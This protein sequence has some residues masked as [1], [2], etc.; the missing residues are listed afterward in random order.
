M[1]TR[2]QS[3]EEVKVKTV[4]LLNMVTSTEPQHCFERWKAPRM[5]NNPQGLELA[6]MVAKMIP[7]WLYPLDFAKFPL[8]RHYNPSDQGIGSWQACHEFQPS[9]TERPAVFFRTDTKYLFSRGHPRQLNHPPGIKTKQDWHS[10]YS[11]Q[12]A[13]RLPQA[14]Q[15]PNHPIPPLSTQRSD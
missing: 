8:K 11:C 7:V 4:D 5:K 14:T 9:A 3:V 2:F 12:D 15:A 1:E 13:E 10:N 6:N